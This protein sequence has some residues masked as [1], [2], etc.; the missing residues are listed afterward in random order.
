[1]P[2]IKKTSDIAAKWARVTP[3]RAEDYRQGVM[4]PRVSWSEATAAASERY[5]AGIQE[6]IQQDR[7]AKG[8]KAAGDD[9]WQERATTI[10]PA[11]FSEGVAT[12]ESR[13]EEGFAPYA[14][15]IAKTVLPPR[16]AKGDPR[17]LERVKVMSQALRKKKV[18]G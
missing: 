4:N 8:V 15:V 11:R 17:N 18:G 1:M 3:Q 2:E 12:S 7:F 6:A 16:F 14:D 9:R 13:Y 10:G 5:K